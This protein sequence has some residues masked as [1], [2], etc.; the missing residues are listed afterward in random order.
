[1]SELLSAPA[2][3]EI[4]RW[5]AKYPPDRKQ[6]AVLAALRAAQH[7]NGGFLTQALL[8]AVAE[9][10]ELP[11]I[12]VY[13]VA[14]FYSLFE[15]EPFGR[16]SISVCTNI[17]CMMLEIAIPGTGT[18]SL[19]YLVTNLGELHHEPHDPLHRR[20]GNSRLARQSHGPG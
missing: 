10:L 9:Y 14:T 1:M 13:E 16:H 15:L 5:L 6:S 12:A 17:S 2:R 3:A 20:A 7:D 8:D 18:L 19:D 11:P 4:D